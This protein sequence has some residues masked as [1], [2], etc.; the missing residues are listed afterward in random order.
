MSESLLHF[1]RTAR[2]PIHYA[3]LWHD[4]QVLRRNGAAWP[5]DDEG[6]LRE[7]LRALER[8]GLIRWG[9]VVEAVYRAETSPQKELFV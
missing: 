6:T 7:Q 1:L 5:P 8:A 2:E 3:Q 4:L 9:E